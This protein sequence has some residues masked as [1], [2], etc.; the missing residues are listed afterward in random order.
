MIVLLILSFL[1]LYRSTRGFSFDRVEIKSWE[2]STDYNAFIVEFRWYN[3]SQRKGI[4][5]AEE[6][7]ALQEEEYIIAGYDITK[8]LWHVVKKTK[9]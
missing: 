4:L 8:G 6:P 9:K 2:Y 7:P 1:V 3:N 5:I